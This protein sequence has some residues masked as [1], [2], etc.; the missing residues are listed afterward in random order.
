MDQRKKA[1]EHADIDNIISD[2]NNFSKEDKLQLIS[3][4]IGELK[5]IH[6][7]TEEE[8][9]GKDKISIPVG[10]FA[11]DAL[12]SLEAIVKYLKEECDL[13]LSKIAKI[14]NRSSKTI[15]STYHNAA[16]K[17][18]LGF[19]AVSRKIMIPISAIS[20]R[21]FSTLESI[22]GFVK[23]L[24]YTNHEVALMLRLDDRT[25]WCVYDKVKKKGGKIAVK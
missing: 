13:R 2:F 18:P 23:E 19:G 8:I 16:K 20:N 12:S 1:G 17:M 15:W 3:S 7:I 10:I 21:S 25:I 22:V 9:L 5:R 6:G 4:F 24:G 11:T 14:L